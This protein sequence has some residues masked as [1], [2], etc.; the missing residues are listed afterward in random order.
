MKSSLWAHTAEKELPLFL[1]CR[2]S[3]YVQKAYKSQITNPLFSGHKMRQTILKETRRKITN[4]NGVLHDVIER[5]RYVLPGAPKWEPK[6]ANE[7]HYT[8]KWEL[9]LSFKC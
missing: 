3:S 7:N 6:Q 9:M 4:W 8:L 1:L 5:V 2:S